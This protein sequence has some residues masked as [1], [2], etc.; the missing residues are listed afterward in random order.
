MNSTLPPFIPYSHLSPSYA[1]PHDRS[2]LTPSG[3]HAYALGQAGPGPSS[4]GS[5]SSQMIS[6]QDG[7]FSQALRENSISPVDG[8]FAPSLRTGVQELTVR[9]KSPLPPHRSLLRLLQSVHQQPRLPHLS[10]LARNYGLLLHP[11]ISHTAATTTAKL[12][13][14]H[15]RLT[16][17]RER[18]SR[19]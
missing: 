9:H 2:N 18:Q 5:A 4:R 17:Q 8:E 3:Q 15:L 13:L 7:Y 19:P 6:G 1:L 14:L 12:P 10:R 11:P 16:Y